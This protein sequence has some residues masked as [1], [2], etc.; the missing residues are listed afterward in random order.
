MYRISRDGVH[1]LMGGEVSE[2]TTTLP[3]SES[4]GGGGGGG[5]GDVNCVPDLK[6]WEYII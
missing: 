4:L 3:R 6:R 1:Y 2:H 5:R